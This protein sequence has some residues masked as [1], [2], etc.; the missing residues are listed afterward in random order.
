M[1]ALRKIHKLLLVYLL[2][3]FLASQ[4]SVAHIH[5][6]EQHTHDGLLHLHQVQPHNHFSI[7]AATGDKHLQ[8]S[9]TDNSVELA[10]DSLLPS[11]FQYKAKAPLLGLQ[12]DRSR[13]SPDSDYYCLYKRT[14]ESSLPADKPNCHSIRSRGPPAFPVYAI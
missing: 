14:L 1:Q 12:P 8:L 9:H 2:T 7:D 6:P 3:A 5:L 11:A 10:Q 4:W 13:L